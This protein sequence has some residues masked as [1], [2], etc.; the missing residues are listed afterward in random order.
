MNFRPLQHPVGEPLVRNIP[1]VPELVKRFSLN[2]LGGSNHAD[3]RTDESPPLDGVPWYIA[4]NSPKHMVQVYEN[5]ISLIPVG[6]KLAG[7][8]PPL[9]KKGDINTFSKKSRHRMLSILNRMKTAT[10]NAP[11]FITLTA[12]HGEQSPEDFRD[13]YF[14]KFLKVLHKYIGHFHYIWRLE[15]HKDGYPHIHLMLWSLVAKEQYAPEV[16]IQKIKRLWWAIIQDSTPAAKQHSCNCKV[17]SDR[18][19]AMKYLSKYIAKEDGQNP[20]RVSGRRWGRSSGLNTS[21]ITV[22]EVSPEEAVNIRFT[23]HRWLKTLPGFSPRGSEYVL[24]SDY[25]RLWFPY[26]M[27]INLLHFCGCSPPAVILGNYYL[28]YEYP[29][30]EAERVAKEYLGVEE[31]PFVPKF[32]GN[33]P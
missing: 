22:F 24:F 3:G 7:G 1:E 33:A 12:R 17:V 4:H 10:Y 6:N 8:K 31:L 26:R 27:T 14:R 30:S 23:L 13:K 18:R 5:E 21:P 20:L 15:P 28:R 29:G 9:R 32:T 25:V 19:G 11:L 16:A 2:I